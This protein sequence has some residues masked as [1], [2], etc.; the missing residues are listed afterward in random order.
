MSGSERRF[1][2]VRED[3]LPEAIVKTARA[4]EILL[5]G[6]ATKVV[7]AV[8]RADLS[9]SAFY[10]YKDGVFT[11]YQWNPGVTVTLALVLEHRSGILSKV[12]S[13]LAATRANILTINQNIPVHGL[14]DVSI[15]FET[16]EM[17][18]GMDDITIR[19]QALKG[20]REVNLMGHNVG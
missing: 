16:S 6:K 5:Q 2:L 1:F 14:A 12:L 8:K 3:L 7:E 9:R 15:T 10:K 17:E 4:K 18:G 20:V 13:T 11:F 19:L